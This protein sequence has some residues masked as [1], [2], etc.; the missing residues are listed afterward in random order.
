MPI[1]SP[2]DP[3]DNLNWDWP[4]RAPGW[5]STWEAAL[6]ADASLQGMVFVATVR[7]GNA[8]Y[9]LSSW[10]FSATCRSNGRVLNVIP[11]LSSDVEV[12]EAYEP[13]EGST[14]TRSVPLAIPNQYVDAMTAI[15]SGIVLAGTAEISVLVP[16]MDWEDRLSLVDGDVSG[17]VSF[18]DFGSNVEFDLVDPQQTTAVVCPPYIISSATQS[19]AT[20]NAVGQRYPLV[21]GSYTRIPAMQVDTYGSSGGRWLCCVMQ[22]GMTRTD[23]NAVYI[24]GEKKASG[25]ASY[26]WTSSVGYDADNTPYLRVTFNGSTEVPWDADVTVDVQ[27]VS[28]SGSVEPVTREQYLHEFI[29]FLLEQ[30]TTLGKRRIHYGLIGEV[31]ARFGRIPC[32]LLVNGSGTDNSATTYEVV[33]ERLANSFP[34]LTFG[35]VDG[36]FGPIPT[37]GRGPCVGTLIE[38]VDLL[39][40]ET[41]WQETDKAS[42]VNAFT[43]R[44]AYDPSADAYASVA[45]RDQTSSSLCLRSVRAVGGERQAEVIES[46]EVYDDWVAEVVTDWMVFHRAMPSYYVE[47]TSTLAAALRLRVGQNVY[48]LIPSFGFTS[49]GV[50]AT[51]VRKVIRAGSATLGFRLYWANLTNDAS[52][53]A[54][55][56]ASR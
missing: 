39:A 55:V 14:G 24:D 21:L 25:D 15:R 43:Y 56:S 49:P 35:W 13:G 9:Y 1:L 42:L 47:W 8:Y 31:A 6:A 54:T 22:A 36:K 48:L 34:M 23:V 38:G 26:G 40:R 19:A 30:Y 28:G 41:E 29:R 11:C 5:N 37:D 10:A 32:R 4:E 46:T 52:G 12:E 7:L 3:T 2:F 33:Q 44:Y 50:K 18:G 45:V 27:R 17:G 53:G 51:V 20:T 16:G